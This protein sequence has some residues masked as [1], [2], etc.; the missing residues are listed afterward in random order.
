VFHLKA[1]EVIVLDEADRMFDLGFIKDIR[2]VLRRLPPPAE[3][4]SMLFSATMS[5]RVS[6]LAYEHMNEP[7]PLAVEAD[8]VTADRVRQT[9]Y[10]TAMEDKVPLLIGLLQHQDS[11]RS[12][13]FGCCCA[14]SAASC[15]CWSP[16]TSPHAG[17]TSPT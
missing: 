3:R 15:R 5:A 6:E 11:R 17:C 14:S 1:I 12:I 16:P 2:Y 10:H 4:L 8:K 9:L 13:V 7:T